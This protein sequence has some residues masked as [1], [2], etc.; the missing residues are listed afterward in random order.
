MQGVVRPLRRQAVGRHGARHVGALEAQADLVEAE[1]VQQTDVAQG[2]LHHGLRGDAPVFLQQGLF[3]AASVDADADGQA[4]GPAG[5][6][7]LLHVLPAADVPRVD[8]DGGHAALRRRQGQAV[9]EMDIRH[10][11]NG[12]GIRDLPQSCRGLGMGH[13]QAHDLRPRRRQG[14]DLGQGGDRVFG[15]RIAHA[16][17]G[18]RRAAPHGNG[19]HHQTLGHKTPPEEGP[20]P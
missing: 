10:Q 17:D 8:A 12:G 13:R 11:G 15:L 5:R 20:I 16:L 18:D 14:P 1:V 6:R 2:A 9:V 7:H 4:V 3:Q 19:A